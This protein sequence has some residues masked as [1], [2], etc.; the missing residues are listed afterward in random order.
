MAEAESDWIGPGKPEAS[1]RLLDFFGVVLTEIPDL[2]ALESD[3]LHSS[4]M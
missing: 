1:V 2:F 4:I 3:K